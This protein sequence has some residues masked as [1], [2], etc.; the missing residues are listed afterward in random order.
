MPKSRSMMFAK[1][2]FKNYARHIRAPNVEF[3]NH[4]HGHRTSISTGGKLEYPEL[5]ILPPAFAATPVLDSLDRFDDEHL[6]NSDSANAEAIEL[7]ALTP[8]ESSLLRRPLLMPRRLLDVPSDVDGA[9]VDAEVF[10]RQSRRSVSS[11][12]LALS[13]GPESIYS[14]NNAQFWS[15]MYESCVEFPRFSVSADHSVPHSRQVSAIQCHSSAEDEV[16][17]MNPSAPLLADGLLYNP[18]MATVIQ[19]KDEMPNSICLHHPTLAADKLEVGARMGAESQI[20]CQSLPARL[21]HDK[22][23]SVCSIDSIRA[24][25][26]DLW[27]L[28]KETEEKERLRLMGEKRGS[29][30]VDNIV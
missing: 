14:Q 17:E 20:S 3:L 15:R 7:R 27:K 2:F 19:R 10:N 12:S 24:S 13:H 4:G 18:A 21:G 26:M 22:R 1:E 8:G 16:D 29:V 6:H 9:P 23:D 11:P 25:S 30:E 28:L 5:E